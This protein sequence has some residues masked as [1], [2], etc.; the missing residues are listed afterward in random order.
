MELCRTTEDYIRAW[1]ERGLCVR[2][3]LTLRMACASICSR[4]HAELMYSILHHMEIVI[5]DF[6]DQGKGG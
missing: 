3:K 5:R 6:R 2:C 1:G 4:C